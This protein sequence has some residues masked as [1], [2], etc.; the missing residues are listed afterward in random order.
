[1]S[2]SP[3]QEQQPEYT[4]VF[5]DVDTFDIF[6]D[7]AAPDEVVFYVRGGTV[8]DILSS[9]A[10]P[11]RWAEVVPYA[12][13]STDEHTQWQ[14]DYDAARKAVSGIQEAL[15]TARLAWETARR[16]AAEQLAGVWEEYRPTHGTIAERVKEATALVEAEDARLHELRARKAD[17]AKAAEDAVLGPQTWSAYLPVGQASK[18]A[19]DMFVPVLH[20]TGC[21]VLRGRDD[22]E[23]RAYRRLRAGEAR[24]VLL[25]GGPETARG[26]MTGRTLPTRLCGRCK[27]AASL[28]DALGDVFDTWQAEVDSLQPPLPQ[29]LKIVGNQLRKILPDYIPEHTLAKSGYT[30]SPTTHTYRDVK[31]IEPYEALIGWYDAAKKYITREE[32][33][34][35]RALFDTLPDHGWSVR[36]IT[37]EATG[38]GSPLV[39]IRKMTPA[40]IKEHA[41]RKQAA[42][43]ATIT[44]EN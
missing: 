36:S 18:V 13:V 34:R 31:T 35:L 30:L 11:D 6:D 24:D 17:E 10:R 22:Q 38:K 37:G 44:P 12:R 14:K 19:P 4:T 27:P 5:D 20:L 3:P 28:R 23:Y 39:A 16:A 43:T 41:A 21:Q 25:G 29:K 9:Q 42:R 8:R 32:P 40:E 33:E 15:E 1:M 26:H 2:D 7:G